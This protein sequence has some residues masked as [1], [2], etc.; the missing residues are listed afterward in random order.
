MLPPRYQPIKSFAGFKPADVKSIISR[1]GGQVE[2]LWIDA[3]VDHIGD[4]PV[5]QCLKS[6]SDKLA[7][8]QDALVALHRLTHQESPYHDVWPVRC[9]IIHEGEHIKR[10]VFVT[11]NERVRFI[12]KSENNILVEARAGPAPCRKRDYWQFSQTWIGSIGH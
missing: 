9:R 5:I 6:G 2:E 10:Y 3:T 1:T 7:H 11:V 12:R 4:R 8:S